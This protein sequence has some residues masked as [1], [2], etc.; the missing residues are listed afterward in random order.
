ML[1]EIDKAELAE[2]IQRL[3]AGLV[4]T[5]PAG[6][7]LHL[8]GGFRYRLLDASPRRSDDIDYSWD[9]DL[10]SKRDELLE[11]FQRKLL[12][13]LKRTFGYEGSVAK[14]DGPGDDST[15]VKVL[16][17]AFY[18]MT[19]PG[20]RIVLPV[21]ITKIARTDS[22]KAIPA[23][24]KI[25]LTVSDQDMVESKVIALLNR[26]FVKARDFVDLFLFQKNLGK[27]SARRLQAKLAE[28]QVTPESV[29]SRMD[30]LRDNAV[31]HTNNIAE[32]VSD[33]MDEAARETL[34]AGGG[35][36]SI[37]ESVIGVLE[38]LLAPAKE[39]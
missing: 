38:D 18:N 37:Y 4:A 13:E 15:V 12:P 2:K 33:Q 11:L 24:S 28:L 20:S 31:V 21:E 32:V 17:L 35:A 39:R 22:P 29:R 6:R 16:E 23:D 5:S 10:L 14:D 36:K 9:N 7:G 1:H 26:T 30:S 8:I 3:V 19:I 25:I 27:D 34:E